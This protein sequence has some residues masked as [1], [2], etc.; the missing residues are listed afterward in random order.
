MH[1]IDARLTQTEHAHPAAERPV[2]DGPD[3]ARHRDV[4]ALD[5]ARQHHARHLVRLIAV[6][7]DRQHLRL[8]RGFEHARAGRAGRVIDDVHTGGDL[9]RGDRLSLRRIAERIRARAG[10][11]RVNH[12]RPSRRER[13]RAIP[14]F[15]LLDQIDVH[16][17]DEPDVPRLRGERRRR[18][19]EER[20]VFLAKPQARE[21]RRNV[22]RRRV[23]DA[24]ET[25]PRKRA[26]NIGDV[27]R[28]D[29]PDADDEIERARRKQTHRTLTVLR[30]RRLGEL[31]RDAVPFGGEGQTSVRRVVEALVA[32]TTDVEHQA[33]ARRPGTGGRRLFAGRKQRRA[34]SRGHQPQHDATVHWRPARR[35]CTR[36]CDD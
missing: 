9:A 18:P 36:A 10:V 6:D 29:V 1:P 31:E 14:R 5:H 16:P 12:A 3:D 27:A 26:S 22:L 7:A 20:A 33:D 35:T 21:V 25:H 24:A 19:D 32:A 28:E 4:D 11:R 13:A 23:V 15:E 30:A 8:A 34:G 2:D 17:A